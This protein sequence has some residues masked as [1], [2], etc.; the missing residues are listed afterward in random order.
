MEARYI[1]SCPEQDRKEYQ[2]V[3]N[4]YLYKLNRAKC[5]YLNAA[6]E[7]IHG[8]QWTFLDSWTPL[9]KSLGEPNAARIKCITCGRLW[10]PF[11][12]IKLNPYANYSWVMQDG[13]CPKQS[14]ALAYQAPSEPMLLKTHLE[15]FLP[16]I[17][18]LINL[19][20]TSC[21]FPWTWR[22]AIVNPYSRRLA[23][24]IFAK[25]INQ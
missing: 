1:K 3:R 9:L 4:V 18:R 24:K 6:I 20:Q 10:Y 23:L 11:S 5:L 13:Y 2:Q 12:G 8:D 7:D 19:S 15:A 14:P 25:T 16:L 21:T 22:R 17:T